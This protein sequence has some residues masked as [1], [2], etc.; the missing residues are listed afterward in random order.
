MKTFTLPDGRELIIPDDPN[1]RAQVGYAI[2]QIPEYGPD[3]AEEYTEGTFLGQAIEAFAG[4][5]R[6]IAQTTLSGLRGPVELLAQ[7][8]LGEGPLV[9]VVKKKNESYR[10][11]SSTKHC[12]I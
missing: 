7:D 12:R 3:V 5:P 11:K 8:S 2:S 9:R 4:I 1:L 6:G 10:R